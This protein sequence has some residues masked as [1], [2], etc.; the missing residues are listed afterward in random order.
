MKD[1]RTVMST[2]HPVVSAVASARVLIVEDDEIVAL[3]L[4]NTLQELGYETAGIASNGLDAVESAVA[5][6][7]D[8]V[9]MDINLSNGSDGVMV[10]E[11]MRSRL[12]V[13]VIFL[14]AYGD[15]ETVARTAAA[16]AFG[17]LAKPLRV[18]E[19][20]AAIPIALARHRAAKTLLEKNDWLAALL[21]S[22]DEGVIAADLQG[23]VT[24]L[25][26]QAEYLTGWRIEEALGK[27]AD[28]IL[29][30]SS[31]VGDKPVESRIVR[32][33]ELDAHLPR[34]RFLLR[35]RRAQEI[36]VEESSAPLRRDEELVGAF[37]VI[38]DLS[39]T[40]RFE[41]AQKLETV[42][43]LAGG[44]AHDF[45]NLLSVVMGNTS[46]VLDSLPAY[47]DELSFLRK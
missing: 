20:R 4:S 22:I 8:L 45:N 3:D 11:Q 36:P 39:E 2:H 47:S 1:L 19:L 14:T 13:P 24:Y 41:Q 35:N 26:P 30:L 23:R 16:G 12:S 9:L 34:E 42:G 29:Q 17:H 7:P 38:R 10:A 25:N 37:S 28:A 43:V 18:D 6:H 31:Q 32:A 40:L 21:G 33:G 27:P 5:G 46:L 44:V 15:Q